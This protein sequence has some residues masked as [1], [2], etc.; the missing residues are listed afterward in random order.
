VP[1]LLAYQIAEIVSEIFLFKS[2]IAIPKS[3]HLIGDMC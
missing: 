1:P 2:Q 3:N